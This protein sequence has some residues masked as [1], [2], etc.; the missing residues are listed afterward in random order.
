MKADEER[1]VMEVGCSLRD[2]VFIRS[3]GV[4]QRDLRI[5]CVKTNVRSALEVVEVG[6]H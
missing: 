4:I 1:T 5:V 3:S 2:A 6:S